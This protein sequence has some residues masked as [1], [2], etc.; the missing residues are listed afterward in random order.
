METKKQKIA[1]INTLLKF[2]DASNN[3]SSSQLYSDILHFTV[4]LTFESFNS[5]NEIAER[6]YTKGKKSYES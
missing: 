6:L 1:L 3:E 4:R 5:C 2:Y